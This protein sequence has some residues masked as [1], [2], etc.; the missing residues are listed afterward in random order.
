MAETDSYK[1]LEVS[2][3]ASPEVI[4]A[5]YRRLA[6]KYHPDSGES[7]DSLRMVRINRAYEALKMAAPPAGAPPLSP[8]EAALRDAEAAADRGEWELVQQLASSALRLDSRCLQAMLLLTEVAVVSE[9]WE[10]ACLLSDQ[11]IEMEPDNE[12]GLLFAAEAA[13]GEGDLLLARG[14]AATILQFAPDHAEAQHYWE[15]AQSALHG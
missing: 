3:N 10:D 11:I 6:R 8:L 4:Q 1:E 15:S 5:A 9:R 14:Y 7:P 2:R 12:E 13:L